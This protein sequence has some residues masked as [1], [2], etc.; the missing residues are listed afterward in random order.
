MKDEL[1]EDEQNIKQTVMRT[2]NCIASDEQQNG[3]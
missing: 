1:N 2:S 3:R